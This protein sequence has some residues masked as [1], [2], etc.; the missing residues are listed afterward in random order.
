ME[1]VLSTDTSCDVFKSKL[2]Q[3]DIRYIPLTFTIDGVCYEDDFD[4]DQ[5][6]KD[7]YQKIRNGAM[8]TTA[9]I[10]PEMHASFFREILS[11]GV[12]NIV[13]L[14]LSGGLSST[15]QSALLGASEAEKDFP[16]SKI[17][18]VDTIGATQAHG[19]LLDKAK[20]MRDK[21][22]TAEQTFEELNRIKGNVHAWIIADDLMHLKRGGRVSGAAAAVGTLLKIKPILIINSNGGLSVVHK[23]KGARKALSYM[24]DNIKEH[25]KDYKTAN[26]WLASADSEEYANELISML[27]AEG[28]EGEIKIGWIGPVIGSHTGAGT[29]GIVFEGTPRTL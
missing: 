15:Y 8:P 12:K 5:Q 22:Y 27:R 28:C 9:Q 2:R 21:L 24:V 16:G 20:Q 6:Y 19:F 7:F 23:A 25:C 3:D 17:Y 4:N 26:I 11:S 18:I 1:F 10:N 29:L 13:H 14:S